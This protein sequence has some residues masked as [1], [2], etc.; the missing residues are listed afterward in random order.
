MSNTEVVNAMRC[1]V[2]PCQCGSPPEPVEDLRPR[3]AERQ[4]H[5]GPDQRRTD[6]GIL[7]GPEGHGED[8]GGEGHRRAEGSEEPPQEDAGDP[9]LLDEGLALREQVWM[10]RQRPEADDRAPQLRADP[11]RKPVPKGG[12]ERTRDPERPEREA[13][14]AGQRPDAHQ[15]RPRGQDQREEPQRLA[16]REREHQGGGPG[17]VLADK[18]DEVTGVRVHI[19]GARSSAAPVAPAPGPLPA[20]APRV[21]GSPASAVGHRALITTSATRRSTTAKQAPAAPPQPV[22]WPH[23][24]PPAAPRGWVP[25]SRR[26]SLWGNAEWRRELSQSSHVLLCTV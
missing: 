19:H 26:L 21:A 20:A 23:A 13:A 14:G 2:P 6:V 7:E 4:Q 15:G 10:A 1:A 12:A 17:L 11:I 25:G 5:S 9:P 16:E 22:C 3:I 24:G 8:A 18:F